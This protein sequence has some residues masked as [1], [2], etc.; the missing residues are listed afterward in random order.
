MK[1]PLYYPVKPLGINQGFGQNPDY[2]AKFKDAF[3]NPLKGHDG[4]DFHAPHGTP[5]HAAHDG[6]AQYQVDAH[7]GDGFVIRGQQEFDYNG[8]QAFFSSMYWHLCAADDPQFAP[9][10]PTDGTQVSVKAGDLIGYADNTGAP[11]ESSGDHLHFGL[12][13]IDAQGNLIEAKNGFNGRIDPTPYFN[14]F[15]AQDI[16]QVVSL[17]EQLV[18]KLQEIVHELWNRMQPK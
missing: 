7:G 4:I 9:V 3:G 14:G 16:P 18:P 13:P 8:G 1:L 10:L 6:I 11:Y 5:V 2:Y 12:F 15:F 17:F